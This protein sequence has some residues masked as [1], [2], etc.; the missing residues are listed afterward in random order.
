MIFLDTK[1]RE[2]MAPQLFGIEHILYIVITAFL[3]G[4]GLLVAKNMRKQKKHRI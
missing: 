1:E 2:I 4:I 3:G